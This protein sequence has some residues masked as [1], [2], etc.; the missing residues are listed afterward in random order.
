MLVLTLW[1]TIRSRGHNH[2][3][4]P[5]RKKRKKRGRQR[6]QPKFAQYVLLSNAICA[7]RLRVYVCGP[8]VSVR[9]GAASGSIRAVLH[10]TVNPG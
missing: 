9:T 10:R 3:P 7:T 8:W 1:R 5:L 2:F 6:T 4:R